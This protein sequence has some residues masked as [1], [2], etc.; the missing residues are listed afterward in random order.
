M[1]DALSTIRILLIDD[2]RDYFTLIRRLMERIGSG[3]YLLEWAATYEAGMTQ[4][5]SNRYDVYLVDYWLGDRT[6]I[7]FL[8]DARQ[9]NMRVPIILITNYDNEGVDDTALE[10]GAADYLVKDQM[11]PALLERSIRY[12]RTRAQTLEALRHSE[13]QTRRVT[14]NMLD[15]IWQID[16]KG[17]IQFASPSSWQILGYSSEDLIGS[18]YAACINPDEI[19]TVSTLLNQ[20]GRAEYRAIHAAGHYLWVETVAAPLINE[21]GNYTGMIL[22]SRNIEDR[23]M[24]EQALRAAKEAAESANLAKSRFLATMSHELRTPLTTILGYNELISSE[25][26]ANGWDSLLPDLQQVEGAGR[27]LLSL[28]NNVLDL[29]KIEAGKLDAIPEMFDVKRLLEDVRLSTQFQIDQNHNS[30]IL[31]LDDKLGDMFTDSVKVRQV[32][33]NLLGNAAKFTQN[34]TIT[35]EARRPDDDT[36]VFRVIDTGIGM[37]TEQLQ[38][39]FSDFTQATPT[40]AREYGGS[41]LGLAITRGFCWIMGGEIGVSSEFGKGSIFTVRLPITLPGSLG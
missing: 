11:T 25:A 38:M 26:T 13:E 22:A 27:H 28:I 15:I 6:G 35:L 5:L 18:H 17:I 4:L 36:M 8:T 3:K 30:L 19:D 10:Q 41:G 23:K 7:E 12:A 14:D 2:D 1:P 24:A 9:R 29:A 16:A 40:T 20:Q 39:V 34:G 33:I 32:L 21:T 31:D 37:T